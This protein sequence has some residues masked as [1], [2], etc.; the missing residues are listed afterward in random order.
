MNRFTIHTS[1]G[2][3]KGFE[4]IAI[5]FGAFTIDIKAAEGNN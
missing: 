2:V 5:G 4:G 3:E 1:N